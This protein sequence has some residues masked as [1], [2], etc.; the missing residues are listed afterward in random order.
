MAL[1]HLLPLSLCKDREQERYL[2]DESDFYTV[3]VKAQAEVEI[4]WISAMTSLVLV[5]LKSTPAVKIWH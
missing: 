2:E 3:D 1:A 5:V 4:T